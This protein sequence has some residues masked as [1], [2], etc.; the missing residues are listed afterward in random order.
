MKPNFS[1][2]LE[3]KITKERKNEFY[4]SRSHHSKWSYV[5]WNFCKFMGISKISYFS[6]NKPIRLL[7]NHG[8]MAKCISDLHAGINFKQITDASGSWLLTNPA[9]FC[10]PVLFLD[11]NRLGTSKNVLHT[12]IER[13]WKSMFAKTYKFKV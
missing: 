12:T 6:S 1:L 3:Y 10:Y 5:Y 7:N 8:K 4:F 9:F 11:L 2:F 13:M